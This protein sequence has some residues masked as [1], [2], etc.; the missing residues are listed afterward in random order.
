MA[1]FPSTLN[2][3]PTGFRISR[4]Q[5]PLPH[6]RWPETYT[7][8]TSAAFCLAFTDTTRIRVVLS[9][10]SRRGFRY[11]RR[12]DVSELRLFR[13]NN[14]SLSQ[15]CGGEHQ[16]EKEWHQAVFAH[17]TNVANAVRA[18][19]WASHRQLGHLENSL[20]QPGICAN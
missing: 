17:D 6:H 5:P 11:A 14:G 13:G 15:A 3:A 18:A 9:G 19:K 2:E 8:R 4:V 10:S 1:S 20:R 16:R 12:N 7:T